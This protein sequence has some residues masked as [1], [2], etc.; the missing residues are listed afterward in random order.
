MNRELVILTTERRKDLKNNQSE[1]L[2]GEE[3][4]GK[5]LQIAYNISNLPQYISNSNGS[6]TNYGYLSDG[7]NNPRNNSLS[8]IGNMYNTR[9]KQRRF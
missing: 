4:P 9:K 3:I 5:D 2:R 7:T 8:I 1:W 6:T